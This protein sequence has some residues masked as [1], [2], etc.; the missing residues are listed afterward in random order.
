M[1]YN[2]HQNAALLDG[3]LSFIR[4]VKIPVEHN[5][6]N[7]FMYKFFISSLLLIFTINLHANCDF[8]PIGFGTSCNDPIPFC[9]DNLTNIANTLPPANVN[10]PFPDLC[11]AGS[12]ENAVWYKFIACESTVSIEVCPGSCTDG[13]GGTGIQASIAE[14]CDANS[15]VICNT[16]P[17]QACF[18][19]T[20]SSFIPGQEYYLIL[21]GYGG[22]ICDY[23]INVLEG[24]YDNKYNLTTGIDNEIS[25][26]PIDDCLEKDQ[27][28]QFSV[29][30]CIAQG[31]ACTLPTL[32]NSSYVCYEWIIDPPTAVIDNPDNLSAVDITFLDEGDYTISVVR[33][34]NPILANCA[35]GSCDDPEPITVSINFIDTIFN[36][37]Q[38][39]C[40]GDVIEICGNPVGID[41][42]YECLDEAT[43]TLTIDT[44][45]FPEMEQVDLGLIYLCPDECYEFEGIEY[46]D[47]EIYIIESDTNC[48]FT[49]E[50]E[51]RDLFINIAEPAY[52]LLDCNLDPEFINM[53][54]T[55]NYE[56]DLSYSYIDP[57]GTEISTETFTN[58]EMPGEYKFYVFSPDF[59]FSCIDSVVFTIEIDDVP[60]NFNINAETL[61]CI[62][63]QS[64][65]T[66]N[67]IDVIESFE[68]T[69]PAVENA[70]Q[71]NAFATEPGKYYVEVVGE[72]G[73][74]GIDSIEIGQELLPADISID[75][76]NLNC[77][78][79]STTLK[80]VSSVPVDSVLWSGPFDFTSRSLEPMVTDTGVYTANMFAA[81][82]CDYTEV[83]K[84]L[85]FYEEPTFDINQNLIWDCGTE[86]VTLNSTLLSGNDV[87][88]EWSTTEGEIISD[89][90]QQEITVGSTGMYFL[91]VFDGENGCSNMDTFTIETDPNIPSQV[92]LD[93]VNPSC[94]GAENG[95]LEIS[96]IEGGTGP[97]TF[98]IADVVTQDQVISD[99]PA[100]EYV[101]TLVDANGCEL[102]RTVLLESPLEIDADL[103]APEMAIF[104]EIVELSSIYDAT[105]FDIDMVNWYNS[106]NELIGT[107]NTITHQMKGVET[108]IMEVIDVN[109][110]SIIKTRTIVLDEDYDY[111]QPNIFT[112]DNNGVNDNFVIFSQK[113]PGEI[114]EFNIFDRWGN[115]VFQLDQAIT[116]PTE[117]TKWG[118]DGTYNGSNV[119]AGVY[120]YY[121]VVE[122]LGVTKEL[123]G[124]V[125]L[126]R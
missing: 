105:L 123:K 64:E 85:G 22:S 70:T 58:I 126:V 56:G 36:P 40:P 53:Q 12:I 113:I 122:T 54:V 111:Y 35:D 21:D 62:D 20:E 46:C 78:L 87:N 74:T 119:A 63:K 24:I 15:S 86:S 50:F 67:A 73:C 124:S 93:I 95:V 81:N 19:L 6:T 114:K 108:F 106:A 117:D 8:P 104:D 61:T 48:A 107:G 102:E 96:D 116:L 84:V 18:T 30:E 34:L 125:T 88:Y 28:I 49:F 75:F 27:S 41:G 100:G 110:C 68:W 47:R 82:G 9:G 29:S 44:L 89:A 39:I 51:L 109:G 2:K 14:G 94:F 115:R 91:E 26:T 72:N 45:A 65:L 98:T 120:V 5:I 59:A 31:G 80:I 90:S 11:M 71:A 121:V 69:G 42:V 101:F 79:I 118:W 43:C 1:T 7:N 77:Q 16:D 52:P 103:D 33:H 38:I 83:V 112:P 32:G 57:T 66:I 60:P 55:T 17:N 3:L 97:F 92:T 10:P 25:H 23:T 37:K 4:S 13:V 99:L 76:D